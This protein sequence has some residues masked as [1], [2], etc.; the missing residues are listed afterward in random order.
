[1]TASVD[2]NAVIE[3]TLS[4]VRHE[5]QRNNIFLRTELAPGVPS[6]SGDRDSIAASHSES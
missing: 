6:V 5:T 1:M 3:D 2:M 4:L